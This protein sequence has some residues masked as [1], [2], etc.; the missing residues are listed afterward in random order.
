MKH[1]QKPDKI[2]LYGGS[3][4]PIHVGHIKAAQMAIEAVGADF[5]YFIISPLSSFKNQIHASANHRAKMVRLAIEKY[6]KMQLSLI[7]VKSKNFLFYQ[8]LQFFQKKHPNAQL[9]SLIGS[10]HLQ[11]FHMWKHAELISENSQIIYL[12]RPG[13]ELEYA[14]N[15]K[16]FKMQKIGET[17]LDISSSTLRKKSDLRMLDWKVIKYINENCVYVEK[18]IKNY[19]S[20]GRWQHCVRTA[21]FAKKLAISCGY[22]NVNDAY[23]AG[24]FHD[25]AKEFSSQ[26]LLRYAQLL[27][28]KKYT[29]IETLHPYAAYYIMKYDYLFEN[30]EILD[31]VYRHTEPIQKDLTLLDKIIYLA[32]KLEP[33]R[34][35]TNKNQLFDISKMQKLALSNIDEAFHQ[36][37]QATLNF[38]TKK[39]KNNP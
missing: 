33:G 9:F 19:L 26:E 5:L 30:K 17:N 15:I 38:Y 1:S 2:I 20:E 27:N 29:S 8:T 6:P 12:V 39:H 37:Y 24:L 3:F 34:K 11:T 25:L 16:Q 35:K 28:I 32:D 18:R 13:F 21:K 22:H 4:D 23:I 7:E 10:D 31:A 14:D 36:V